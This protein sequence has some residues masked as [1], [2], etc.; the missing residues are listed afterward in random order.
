MKGFTMRMW[1]PKT[2]NFIKF[3]AKFAQDYYPEFLGKM[4]VV[5]APWIF[6]G[7]YKLIKGMIDEKT[8]N[9]IVILGSDYK[10]QLLEFVDEDQLPDFLGGTNPASL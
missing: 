4:I 9:K 7:V 6:A 2:I 5:N 3:A 10:Q 8:R 1:T